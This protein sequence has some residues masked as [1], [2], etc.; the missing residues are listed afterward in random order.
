MGLDMLAPLNMAGQPYLIDMAAYPMPMGPQVPVNLTL[1]SRMPVGSY[2]LEKEQHVVMFGPF[3]RELE[4]YCYRMDLEDVVYG[5]VNKEKAVSA[6]VEANGPAPEIE[7]LSLS[8]R[9]TPLRWTTERQVTWQTDSKLPAPVSV[10]QRRM[11]NY[12]A[13]V[14]YALEAIYLEQQDPWIDDP[15]PVE[16][17]SLGTIEVSAVYSVE[18]R[19][20]VKRLSL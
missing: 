13:R 3:A 20:R 1:R 16:M 14:T 8:Y 10:S 19:V 18:L 6:W 9:A 15:Q 5:K 12:Y 17:E 4:W 2:D 11:R 7:S